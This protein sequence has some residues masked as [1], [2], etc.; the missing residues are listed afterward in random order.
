MSNGHFNE[1]DQWVSN[2]FEAKL[3]ESRKVNMSEMMDVAN[4]TTRWSHQ[5]ATTPQRWYRPSVKSRSPGSSLKTGLSSIQHVFPSKCSKISLTGLQD[6]KRASDNES[7]D[8][9][10]EEDGVELTS[11]I[12]QETQDEGN[13][14]A[15]N[16]DEA[17]RSFGFAETLEVIFCHC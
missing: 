15:S 5:P 13:E 11:K 4:D 1:E 16:E 17:E 7:N 8:G 12:K 9:E 14:N 2:Q 6:G 3:N 10:D